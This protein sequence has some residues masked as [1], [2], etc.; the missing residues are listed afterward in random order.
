[1][2][3]AAVGTIMPWTGDITEIPRGWLICNGNTITASD[4]PLLA[5]AIGGTYG[6]SGFSGS[7][8][9]YSGSITLPNIS[10]KALSDID[11]SYFGGGA[12][13]PNTDTS[14]ALSVVSS[15]L[16]TDADNGVPFEYNDI[17]TDIVFSYTPENDFVG[18][19]SGATYD[20]GF[21]SRTVYTSPRKLGRRHTPTHSHPTLVPSISRTNQ[22]RPGAGVSASRTITYNINKAGSDDFLDGP[23]V[24]ISYGGSP[25]NNPGAFG[26]G[27]P[28]VVIANVDS[29]V[30]PNNLRPNNVASSGLSNWIGSE[31]DIPQPFGT[32]NNTPVHTRQFNSIDS[33]PYGPGTSSVP[34]PN[35]NYDDGGANSGDTHIPYEVFFNHSGISF[36]Q[37]TAT[38]GVQDV[39]TAHDHSSFE[40]TY[41]KGTVRM[42]TSP[43]SVQVASN[44]V[45]DNL[46]DALNT[47]VL[48]QTPSVIILYIIRAY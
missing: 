13:E 12:T 14:A 15:Y 1:M 11:S 26:N 36:N 47:R 4:Y 46:P 20:P 16:G 38:P 48:T 32:P 24:F 34:T 35:R 7:F 30:P 18:G 28:G 3:A 29:E 43:I 33:A 22:S 45:P 31:V 6:N 19:I 37:T 9:N 41:D 23:Q 8:P 2:K 10:Q 40:V 17:Y 21:L 27:V 5:Q 25:S 39:I 44:V 42:P